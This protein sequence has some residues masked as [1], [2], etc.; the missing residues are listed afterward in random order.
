MKNKNWTTSPRVALKC[1]FSRATLSPFFIFSALVIFFSLFFGTATATEYTSANFQIKDPVLFPAGYSTSS[2]FSL[3]STIGQFSIGTTTVGVGTPREL[4]AGFE[5]FPFVNSP[6]VSATAGDTQ[7]NLSWTASIGVLGW[8]VS[9]YQV[10]QSTVLGGP[11]SYTNVGAVLAS[12]VSS[13]TNGTQYFFVVNPLD[14]FGNSIATSS[15][16]SAT[17]TGASPPPPPP[18]PPGGGGGSYTPAPAMGSIN[19]SGLAYPNASINLLLG[20][21]VIKTVAADAGGNF[22]VSVTLAEGVSYQ[23]GFSASDVLGRHSSLLVVTSSVVANTTK[24]VAGIFLSPTLDVD[25]AKIKVGESVGISGYA[26]PNAQVTLFISQDPS[27]VTNVYTLTLP[28]S[29]SGWYTQRF[30]IGESFSTGLY[31]SKSRAAIN[32]LSSNL[33]EPEQF[34]VTTDESIK[35]PPR[36]CRLGDLNDDGKVELVDFSIAVYWRNKPLLE[37]FKT[38]EA[39]CLNND[40]MVN[41]LD[42]SLM[43]YYWTG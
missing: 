35:K 17:P 33:S 24:D 36:A 22:I 40:G 41:L 38:K 27:F 30:N 21:A 19:F 32:G 5:Y 20:G 10:G 37:P 26:Y 4:R 43:A 11:Y 15:E 6:V 18:S 9:G 34:T 16:V 39:T 29:P 7:V 1:K 25:T 8:T 42:F 3:T 28:V 12:T 14:A 2:G 23:F 13:L 31:I